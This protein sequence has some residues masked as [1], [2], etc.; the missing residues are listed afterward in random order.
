LELASYHPGESVEGVQAQ[1]GFPLIARE[2]VHETPAPSAEELRVLR[3][4]VYPR[5]AAQ[6]PA[7]A[8]RQSVSGSR[9]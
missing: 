7:F 2:D 4:E 8:A 9:V 1:T 3:T 5:L 6:Y